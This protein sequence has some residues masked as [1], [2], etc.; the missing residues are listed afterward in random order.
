MSMAMMAELEIEVWWKEEAA[1]GEKL[2]S[3][4]EW[5][6]ESKDKRKG[7]VNFWPGLRRGDGQGAGSGYLEVSK[8]YIYRVVN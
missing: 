3:R 4:R 1:G 8:R 2:E 7:R 6:G 5:D